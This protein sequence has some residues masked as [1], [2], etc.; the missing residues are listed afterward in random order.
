MDTPLGRAVG[1]SLEVEESILCLRG[2]G[3]R[4]LEELVTVQGGLLLSS[5]LQGVSRADGEER[6]RQVI[7]NGQA[8]E[9]VGR[10]HPNTLQLHVL[11]DYYLLLQF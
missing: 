3:P 1:N 6:I 4:D 10:S 9:K 2:E 11:T 8:L 7:H 5:V